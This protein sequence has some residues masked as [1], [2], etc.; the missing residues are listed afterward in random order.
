MR[1][2]F[3]LLKWL[4][5]DLSG[6]NRLDLRSGI[7]P[8]LAIGDHRLTRRH[9]L[10]DNCLATDGCADG[11]YAGLDGLVLLHYV[12]EL[13][14]RPRLYS[15]GR[16]GRGIAQGVQ[17]QRHVDEL[18]RPQKS[19]FVWNGRFQLYG[20]RRCVDGVVDHAQGSLRHFAGGVPRGHL[21][22]KLAGILA[23]SNCGKLI[24]RDTEGHEDGPQAVDHYQRS[25]AIGF[26]VVSGVH[27]QVASAARDGRADRTLSEVELAPLHG[28]E[29]ALARGPRPLDTP[30]IGDHGFEQRGGVGSA[31]VRAAARH[32]R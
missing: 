9:T 21:H 32:Y 2:T 4:R 7:Q 28:S 12:N 5:I 23:L 10:F 15:L 18:A 31:L 1:E 6:G 25:I 3:I 11:H 30:T 20:S 24:F 13:A 8:E 27:E 22:R 29:V 16:H 26:H 17:P 14:L 19:S